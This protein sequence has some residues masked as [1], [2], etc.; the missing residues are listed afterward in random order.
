[1][2]KIILILTLL[3]LSTFAKET[4]SN[5]AFNKLQEAEKFIEK[6]EYKQASNILK[7]LLK[8][9]NNITTS[10]ALQ[11]FASIYLEQNKYKKAISNYEKILKL[12]AFKTNEINR[13]KYVLSQ[14]YLSETLYKKSIKYSLELLKSKDTN[15]ELIYQNL[16][17]AYYYT[18]EYKQ[19][20]IYDEKVIENKKRLLDEYLQTPKEKQKNKTKPNL[21]TWYKILYSSYF[22]LKQYPKAIEII[23][24]MINTF[25]SKE[26]YWM[27]L[28][29]I[30]Q[31][32]NGQKQMLSTLELAYDKGLINH[33]NNIQYFINMLL[34]N[35]L[36]NKAALLIEDGIKKGILKD[37]KL[38]F[39]TLV[40]AHLN[41]KN[42]KRAIK[43]LTTNVNAKDEYYE[44]LLGN[45]YY[46]KSNYKKVI[47]TLENLKFKKNTKYEG[48]KN[49]LLAL[50]YYE[51]EKEEFSK[52][53]LKKALSNKFEKLRAKK[54][55]KQLGYKI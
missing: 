45:I 25:E 4:L 49:I 14:L 41:A 35:E 18:E 47:S 50:S 52:K 23:K 48:Q 51:L 22:E 2:K 40:N 3:V 44:I 54:I 43:L 31:N 34:Q 9:T 29:L 21:E 27:Q 19:S 53:Y 12:D 8:D 15:K 30:Y 6:K 38:N 42:I 17:L 24:Y 11:S 28:V 10:Y 36:Y 33:K 20:I 37:D 1:M 39:K 13:V 5:S 26:E 46:N 55:I 32:T 7:P 16:T